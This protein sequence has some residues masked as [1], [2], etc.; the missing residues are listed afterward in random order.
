M[1]R[2]HDVS[3]QS[4]SLFLTNK[5]NNKRLSSLWSR[6]PPRQNNNMLP[7]H[8]YFWAIVSFFS[9]SGAFVPFAKP[10]PLSSKV[11]LF[12]KVFEDEGPLGKGITVGKVQIALLAD[13]HSSN[14]IFGMLE[15]K[16]KA[17]GDTPYALARMCYDVCMSLLRK[18]DDWISASS[19]S[20]WFKG[21][22]A[23]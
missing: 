21:G 23:G 16:A 15:R 6:S 3:W 2:L 14:S 13:D 17:D 11:N 8:R 7:R 5:R 9:M 1:D 12:D 22:E 20:Q 10:N 4:F 19:T 18:E